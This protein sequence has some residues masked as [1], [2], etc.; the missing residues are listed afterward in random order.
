MD[1]QKLLAEARAKYESAPVVGRAMVGQYVEPLVDLLAVLV[2]RVEAL[3]K[4]GA[5]DGHEG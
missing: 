1:L 4:R 5:G 2:E 3:E